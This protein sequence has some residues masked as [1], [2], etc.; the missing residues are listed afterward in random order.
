[1]HARAQQCFVVCPAI[2]GR[3]FWHCRQHSL[4]GFMILGCST[5]QY[6][7][8]HKGCNM[9]Q[10][11]AGKESLPAARLQ[12]DALTQGMSGKVTCR[13][14][15]CLSWLAFSAAYAELDAAASCTSVQ[16]DLSTGNCSFRYG[17]HT[18]PWT[19]HGPNKHQHRKGSGCRL[20]PPE[21]ICMQCEA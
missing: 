2:V 12:Q 3:D 21:Q 18:N 6:N 13:A 11:N 9:H 10:R 1:M 20:Q 8:L 7:V 15:M 16:G 17:A 4:H 5:M 14:E 19:I